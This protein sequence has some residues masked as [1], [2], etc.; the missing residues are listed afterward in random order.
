MEF[1][2]SD[3][4]YNT[5]AWIC[6]IVLPAIITL[7]GVIA[8]TMSIPHTEEVLTIA[9][10]INTC[11]ATILGISTANWKA[12]AA[13]EELDYQEWLKEFENSSDKE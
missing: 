6:R 4:V 3:K 11:L 5:L 1:K 13:I 7:Y 9:V 8:H 2:M 12:N 10:A